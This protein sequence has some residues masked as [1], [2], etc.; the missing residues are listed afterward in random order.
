[1]FTKRK[2]F[3]EQ[4][5]SQGFPL[6]VVCVLNERNREICIFMSLC[7]GIGWMCILAYLQNE[8]KGVGGG[9]NS[10]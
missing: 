8:N 3:I 4:I 2:Q 7:N 10:R 6:I 9:V 5:S 1:M